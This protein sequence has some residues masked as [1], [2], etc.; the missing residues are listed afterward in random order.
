MVGIAPARCEREGGKDGDGVRKA[1][2]DRSCYLEHALATRCRWASRTA[3][4]GLIR[5]EEGFGGGGKRGRRTMKALALL[6]VPN[7]RYIM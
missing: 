5:T 1:A 7:A 6:H 4:E 3:V 2:G